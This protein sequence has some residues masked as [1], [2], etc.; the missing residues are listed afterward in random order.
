[1]KSSI[2]NDLARL[3]HTHETSKIHSSLFQPTEAEQRKL[4]VRNAAKKLVDTSMKREGMK[5]AYHQKLKIEEELRRTEH[6]DGNES[7]N[8]EHTGQTDVTSNQGRSSS[9]H[10]QG[11]KMGTSRAKSSQHRKRN[12]SGNNRSALTSGSSTMVNFDFTSR[13][14]T[15]LRKHAHYQGGRTN[16]FA[17]T[18]ASNTSSD[19]VIR[20]IHQQATEQLRDAKCI[21]ESI[22]KSFEGGKVCQFHPKRP[23][24]DLDVSAFSTNTMSISNVTKLED[25]NQMKKKDGILLLFDPSTDTQLHLATVK[26]TYMKSLDLNNE[27]EV[28]KEYTFWSN[29]NYYGLK[30]MKEFFKSN[31]INN[32]QPLDTTTPPRGLMSRAESSSS[33]ACD[34]NDDSMLTGYLSKVNSQRF[35]F[36][37]P[38]NDNLKTNMLPTE[39]QLPE[40][41]NTTTEQDIAIIEQIDEEEGAEQ[42]QSA[43][44]QA[45]MQFGGT[46]K[47]SLPGWQSRSALFIPATKCRLQIMHLNGLSK[48]AAIANNLS[49]LRLY[50][51]CCPNPKA[52]IKKLLEFLEYQVLQEA[53]NMH[54]PGGLS[55]L[56]IAA[57]HGNFEVGLLI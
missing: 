11:V 34:R 25:L 42:E 18:L 32:T 36:T 12:G 29:G 8:S 14:T 33:I 31:K 57:V 24:E 23:I 39:E 52:G 1:M 44:V 28:C 45:A 13:I 16:S 30:L 48:K 53:V 43:N 27:V 54:L 21:F 40:Q 47:C 17:A 51:I 22:C 19:D 35:P 56:N 3:R 6:N 37:M 2:L 26:I 9:N 55:A 50:G 7:V 4:I 41:L 20:E 15:S 49:R 10:Q 46:E 5:Y 38:T